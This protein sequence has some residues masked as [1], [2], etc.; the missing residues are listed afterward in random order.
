MTRLALRPSFVRDIGARVRWLEENAPAQWLEA[1]HDGLSAVQRRIAAYPHSGAPVKEQGRL[2][3]RAAGF[4][5][6]LPYLVYY[7]HRRTQPIKVVYLVRLFH[8]RQRRVLPRLRE[9][10][11]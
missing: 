9:W 10:P 2:A 6:R 5:G 7:V 1:F 4:S 8:Y 3:L 11:S